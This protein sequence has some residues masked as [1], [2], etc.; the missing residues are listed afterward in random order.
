MRKTSV[1]TW[2]TRAALFA[3]TV[4]VAPVVSGQPNVVLIVT[5]D[6]GYVDFGFQG[7]TEIPTPML[8]QL[9][10]QGVVFNQAYTHVACSPS[11]AALLTGAVSERWGYE[12]NIQ[13]VSDQVNDY[14]A[15]LPSEAVTVFERLQ[16]LDY[17]TGVMGKW[18]VGGNDD[19]I[20]DGQIVTPGN[21]PPRQGVDEFIGFQA[22]GG[23][24]KHQTLNPD[25]TVNVTN[26]NSGGRHW[27]DLW[28]DESVNFIDRHYRDSEP[29]FLYTSFNEPHT[30][31][32]PSP[33]INDPRI[34]GLTGE[35]KEYASEM[36]SIDVNVEK[37]VAKLKDP[38]GD[39]VGT[40]D[41]DGID[42]SIFEDTLFIFINDNGGAS[43][44]TADNGP[45][46]G[47]KGS[48][49]EGGVRVP[50]FISGY[51][52]DP[53]VAGTTY[54]DMV[55][56]VDI[57]ATIVAAGGGGPIHSEPIYYGGVTYDGVDVMP[58]VNGATPGRPRD[59]IVYRLQE[60]ITLITPEWKL[61]KDGYSG[62]WEL[63]AF[64]NTG[65]QSEASTDNVAA[66]NPAV[67]EAML[68]RITDHEVLMNKQQFPSIDESIGQFNLFNDFTF[69]SDA[70]GSANWSTA[71]AWEDPAGNG[72]TM[73]D[74][75]SFN[76]TVVHFQTHNSQSYTA[77]NDLR[78]MN[79]MEFI[80]HGFTLEG[81]FTGDTPQAA[82]LDGLSVL[83]AKNFRGQ[84]PT[85]ALTA[86]G[87]TPGGFTFELDQELRL[88]DDLQITGQGTQGFAILGDITEYRAGR[89]ITKTGASTVRF[90]GTITATSGME[91]DEGVAVF[92]RGAGLTGDL[93]VTGLGAA[94]VDTDIQGEVNNAGLLT[95]A[96]RPRGV[97]TR[98]LTLTPGFGDGDVD[99][100]QFNTAGDQDRE[101]LVGLV[102]GSTGTSVARIQR[103]L[104]SFDLSAVP[105]DAV[106]TRADLR[107]THTSADGSSSG[108]V[109]GN[110]ELYE[111][112]ETPV[113]RETG[114]ENVTWLLRDAG[115]SLPWAQPGGTRGSLLAHI[116][117][118][119]LPST[120]GV[121][122]GQTLE[123]NGNRAMLALL[124]AKR[125]ADAF[126]VVLMLP[127][128][129]AAGN[130]GTGDRDLFRFG[131]NEAG[132][133]PAELE[134]V[135]DSPTVGPVFTGGFTQAAG[136]RLAMEVGDSGHSRF[137]VVGAATLAGTIDLAHASDLKDL[138]WYEPLE[139]IY[140]DTVTGSFG[141]I[142]GALLHTTADQDAL[143]VTYTADR[144]WVQRALL[145]DANLDGSIGQADLDVVLLNWGSV[146]G[147]WSAGDFDGSGTVSQADLDA[148]L[149]NWGVST[150]SATSSNVPEPGVVVV[151]ALCLVQRRGG[152][153]GISSRVGVQP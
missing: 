134:L 128:E 77:T 16:A 137:G 123:L 103:G 135:F 93:E 59:E 37:I 153:R 139:L 67:V 104:M 51:G 41:A 71:D 110:L 129:E 73:R 29:F 145:G 19:V 53:S 74:R 65:D 1:C 120:T 38:D 4:W 32:N 150:E 140:A 36:I 112:T 15:G 83:L 26:F 130:A 96:P 25:G 98:Q 86:T 30:P 13:N 125:A 22:P 68:R 75:D 63:Y 8:D 45:L 57:A 11:R 142:T 101:L 115:Q 61:L 114:A 106:L 70:L 90:E 20:V 116:L 27:S 80:A 35:R 47:F 133:G 40:A 94:T 84:P 127:G 21:K 136:G 92:T 39:G 113:F 141:Q 50:A 54:N 23:G 97:E 76:G 33:Y 91:I 48:V 56:S 88:Y 82:R 85:L 138:N 3:L 14:F 108:S 7:S 28:G 9:A 149:L 81:N 105:D 151:F 55:A 95:I 24:V 122:A 148:V 72:E 143:A 147:T 117:N 17:T 79:E 144:V 10:G 102:N 52:V 78:R 60:E 6:A 34:T 69:R 2:R 58:F 49:Y 119:D 42:E 62:N 12:A 131:S 107:L 126:S 118:A 43:N 99:Q 31:V 18:H 124:Q 64:S 152:R 66:Q 100:R 109:T 146:A 89:T 87:D 111:L 121:A 5:D 132:V 46:R 44:N